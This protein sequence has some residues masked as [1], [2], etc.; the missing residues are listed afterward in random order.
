MKLETFS[1]NLWDGY[2]DGLQQYMNAVVE[3]EGNR[4]AAQIDQ[5]VESALKER[6]IG[7][8]IVKAVEKKWLKLANFL[9]WLVKLELR[10]YVDLTDL[11]VKY[12]VVYRAQVVASIKVT[13]LD[14]MTVGAGFQT[15]L[16]LG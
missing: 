1:N 5:L 6:F 8:L 15:G 9:A 10:S 16:S 13:A 3:R 14:R 2:I 7:R 11:G 4:R 12:E